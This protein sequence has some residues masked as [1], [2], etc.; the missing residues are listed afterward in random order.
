MP[1]FRVSRRAL[2]TLYELGLTLAMLQ[3]IALPPSLEIVVSRGL[4]T[5]RV[6]GETF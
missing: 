5:L 2:D 4:R 6:K 3:G 1:F